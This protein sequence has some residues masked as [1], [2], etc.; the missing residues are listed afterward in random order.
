MGAQARV[1]TSSLDQTVKVTLQHCFL[2]VSSTSCFY[3]YCFLSL[4]PPVSVFSTSCQ[5]LNLFLL[6]SPVLPFCLLT[7]CLF[8][9]PSLSPSLTSCG[10]VQVWE[11]SSGE[12]LLSVLFDVEIMSVTTDPCDYFLFC[13]GSDG[14]IFQVSLCSQV[15]Q[16]LPLTSLPPSLSPPVWRSVGTSCMSSTESQSG[17]VF[18][19]GWRREPG[20]QRS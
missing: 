5:F 17:Q 19:V 1:A 9:P 12:L 3:F 8:P 4:L 20:V 6:L 11:L 10:H 15:T 13:G 2:S 14:N 16:A 7:P 18:P